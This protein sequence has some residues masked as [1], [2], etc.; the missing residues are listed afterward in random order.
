[1]VRRRALPRPQTGKAEGRPLDERGL[2]SVSVVAQVP[3]DHGQMQ[4]SHYI[5]NEP[6]P[7]ALSRPIEADGGIIHS[8][9]LHSTHIDMGTNRLDEC[10]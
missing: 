10:V 5:E 7:V 6:G 3:V 1:M 9:P 4:F 2:V 8:S